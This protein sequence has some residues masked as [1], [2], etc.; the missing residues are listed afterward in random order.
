MYTIEVHAEFFAS[1]QLRLQHGALEPLHDHQWY[2]TASVESEILDALETVMDFHQ[3]EQSLKSI[4]A[5][6]NNH[7]LNDVPPFDHAVNPSAER[8]AQ[9]IAELLGPEI[10]APARLR[11]VAI[12]EAPGCVAIFSL[13]AGK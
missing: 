7:H 5:P 8:V 9:R 4:I 3:L 12:T 10:P 11:S 2:I 13:P 6:W 1:H